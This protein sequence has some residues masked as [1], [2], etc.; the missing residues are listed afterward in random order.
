MV[1]TT[2]TGYTVFFLLFFRFFYILTTI[3]VMLFHYESYSPSDVNVAWV[4]QVFYFFPFLFHLLKKT[5]LDTYN[6]DIGRNLDG[7][8][9]DFDS[10]ICFRTLKLSTLTYGDLNH[11]VSIV[12]SN[13]PSIPWST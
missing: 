4:L 2:K 3:T 8:R 9:N 12:M 6:D 1:A 10:P 5:L 13:L 7:P 11:L